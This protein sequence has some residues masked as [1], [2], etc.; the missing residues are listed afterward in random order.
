[1]KILITGAAGGIGSLIAEELSQK[2]DLILVD[3]YRNGFKENLQGFQIHEIDICKPVFIEFVEKNKPDMILHLAAITSLP[4]CEINK[5]ECIDINVSGTVNVL[6]A[7]RNSGVQKIIF[8]ST[9]AIYENND[10]SEAPFHEN[11]Q[12]NPL[13]FYCMSKKMAEDVCQAYVKN[14]GMNIMILRFFNIFGPNQDNKR[15]SP[16]LLNYLVTKV[17]SGEQPILHSDGYQK[18]DYVSAYD[19]VKLFNKIIDDNNFESQ[20]YNVCSGITISV[21]DII[22]ITEETLS[23]FSNPVFR[24]SEM[25]WDSYQ[26]LFETYFPL[27]KYIVDKEVNKFSLGTNQKLYKRYGWQPNPNLKEE[28]KKVILKLVE[29]IKNEV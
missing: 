8:A 2:H 27:K 4:D 16:P 3:N 22:E 21:R 20:T 9:S 1:M 29:R 17:I 13:L 18:R 28:F 12:V 6:E 26:K 23:K 24:P 10:K 25:L 11:L 19:L 5:I 7:A 15:K 14:Y